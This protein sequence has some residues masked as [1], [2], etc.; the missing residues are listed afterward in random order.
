[1]RCLFELLDRESAIPFRTICGQFSLSS[2]LQRDCAVFPA[3]VALWRDTAP[4]AALRLSEYGSCLATYQRL[5]ADWHGLNQ[6]IAINIRI[7]D[8]EAVDALVEEQRGHIE[9]VSRRMERLLFDKVFP[10]VE[11]TNAQE[12]A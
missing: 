3:A 11:V 5:F 12:F 6:D 7:D 8:F 9:R 4:Q 2:K 10:E 1:M